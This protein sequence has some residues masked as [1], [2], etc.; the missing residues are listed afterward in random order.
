M[1]PK[2]WKPL[3]TKGSFICPKEA[4]VTWNYPEYVNGYNK[5]VNYVKKVKFIYFY[6]WKTRV[7]ASKV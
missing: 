5:N 3:I 4:F 1:F 6:L 7:E 2:S